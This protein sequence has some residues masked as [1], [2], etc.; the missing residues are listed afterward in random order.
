MPAANI[1]CGEAKE[2]LGVDVTRGEIVEA[3]LNRLIVKR[4]REMDPDEQHELWKESVDR[5]NAR[6]REENRLAWCGYFSHLAGALRA[7]AED[8]E[9]RRPCWRTGG[10]GLVRCAAPR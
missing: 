5:Y 2:A 6:R 10:R 8:Y 3:D 4:S 9:R 1:C 7:R